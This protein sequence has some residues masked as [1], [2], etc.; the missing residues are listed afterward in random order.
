MNRYLILIC[1]SWLLVTTTAGLADN[2]DPTMSPSSQVKIALIIDDLGY[3]QVAGERALALPGA[4]TYSFLPQTP[5]ARKLASKAH[6]LNKEVMLHQP[7]ESD[8]GNRLGNGALTLDM[9]RVQFTRIL[10]HNLASIPYV[11]GVNNHMGSLLTRD[12]TAM[13]WLM[14]ELRAGG[15]FF[16]DS[17]TTDATVAERVARANLIA[18]SRRHVFLDNT[19]DE[20]EIRRQLRQLLKMARTQGHAIGIAHPYPQTL[21]VLHQELPKLNQQ[22]IELVPVSELINSGRSLWHAYSSPSPKDAKNSKQSP[23]LI[24]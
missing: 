22:G 21:A 5:F 1:C 6:Q 10:Q 17:R 15:L 23:S 4:V 7:M 9:S 24:Y 8:N 16:I 2:S 19:P 13:R 3:Q 11:A 20:I 18:T 14:S 12:P